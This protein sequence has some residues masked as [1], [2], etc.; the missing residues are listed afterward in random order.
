MRLHGLITGAVLLLAASPAAAQS[1]DDSSAPWPPILVSANTPSLSSEVP[2]PPPA[3]TRPLAP[4]SAAVEPVPETLGTRSG[5]AGAGL[6]GAAYLCSALA[7]GVGL[8]ADSEGNKA[9][10]ALFVPVAGPFMMLAHPPSDASSGRA[11]VLV[12]DGVAQVGGIAM[13]LAGIVM[14]QQSTPDPPP[15]KVPTVV[16]T[17]R[18]VSLSWRF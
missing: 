18:S 15:T 14:E 13:I 8:I 4:T 16:A 5:I 9:I 3:P 12:M 11:V 1:D 17:P 10:A 7:A 6:F 2:P